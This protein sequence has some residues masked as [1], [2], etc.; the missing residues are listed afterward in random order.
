[1]PA[2]PFSCDNESVLVIASYPSMAKA[3]K[4]MIGYYKTCALFLNHNDWIG[5]LSVDDLRQEE[6]YTTRLFIA[7]RWQG[8]STE[9][10]LMQVT[11]CGSIFFISRAEMAILHNRS[12]FEERVNSSVES[13]RVQSPLLNG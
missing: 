4:C 7:E 13:S 5:L 3:V 2:F 1:M 12:E 8:S 10:L 9:T 6:S 11:K